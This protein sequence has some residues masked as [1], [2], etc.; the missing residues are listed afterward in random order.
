MCYD[1]SHVLA[2]SRAEALFCAADKHLM[3]GKESGAKVS[4]KKLFSKQNVKKDGTLG[5]L[6]TLPPMDEIQ[7]DPESRC[8]LA[9]IHSSGFFWSA[10][11]NA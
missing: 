1:S 9:A 4:M 7:M 5:K 3:S 11:D 6:S 10:T 8:F 2:L